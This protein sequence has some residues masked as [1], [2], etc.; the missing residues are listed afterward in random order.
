MS[1]LELT[2]TEGGYPP[3]NVMR[4]RT[5]SAGQ[6]ITVTPHTDRQVGRRTVAVV[7]NRKH[8]FDEVV[9]AQVPQVESPVAVGRHQ[10]PVDDVESPIEALGPRLELEGVIVEAQP[11]GFL[12]AVGHDDVLVGC[13]QPLDDVNWPACH[14][15]VEP[16]HPVFV[17]ERPAQQVVQLHISGQVLS[18]MVYWGRIGLKPRVLSTT[19]GRYHIF[20]IPENRRA[21]VVRLSKATRILDAPIPSPYNVRNFITLLAFT[22]KAVLEVG[23]IV[24]HG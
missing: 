6:S 23:K 12:Q 24:P 16:E 15:H 8:N 4:Y 21:P 3:R 18:E 10:N 22:R 9:L 11:G 20:S 1:L 5:C 19:T 17:G 14:V 7:V 13:Q 2:P